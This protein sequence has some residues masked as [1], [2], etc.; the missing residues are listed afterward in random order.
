MTSTT[1]TR[2]CDVAVEKSRSMHSVA[3]PTA[4]SNPNVA[5]VLSRSLSIVF[6][7]PITRSPWRHR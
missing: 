6:G 5:V 3:K 2:P 1:M 4:V 7:T